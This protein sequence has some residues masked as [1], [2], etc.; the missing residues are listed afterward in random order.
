MIHL[1]I[2]YFEE[3]KKE[4]EKLKKAGYRYKKYYS[5]MYD[6]DLKKIKKNDVIVGRLSHAQWFKIPYEIE[7][8]VPIDDEYQH[9]YCYAT[10]INGAIRPTVT[11][12]GRVKEV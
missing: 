10:N 7:V 3:R 12:L 1:S 11:Y 6:S 2:R 4:E 8:F 9:F 5:G